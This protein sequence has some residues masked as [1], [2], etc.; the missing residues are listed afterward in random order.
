MNKYD[1]KIHA[2]L[3]TWAVVVAAVAHST[4]HVWVE[5]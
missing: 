4:M 1:A 2:D 5:V 3:V